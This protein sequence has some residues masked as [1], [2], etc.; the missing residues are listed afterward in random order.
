MLLTQPNIK[1]FAVALSLLIGATVFGAT[2]SPLRQVARAAQSLLAPPATCDITP[3]ARDLA[4][5]AFQQSEFPKAF[6]LNQRLAKCS[7]P[8]AQLEL[9]FMFEFG[10][11]T[12]KN[13]H[14]AALWY[15]NAIR[16][17]AY[18]QK[19]LERGINHYLG[20]N[21]QSKNIKTAARWFRMAAELSVDRY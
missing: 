20:L 8:R 11:G 7:D 3:Q 19:P 16:P 1:R 15:F 10:R 14:L 6:R 18:N 2:H 4:N 5:T 9:G 13:P 12:K 21:G 17:N